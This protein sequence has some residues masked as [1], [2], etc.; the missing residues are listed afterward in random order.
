MPDEYYSGY[1]WY[2][3]SP[4]Q[5]PGI[6]R[7]ATVLTRVFEEMEREGYPANQA[8]LFGFSQGCLMTLEFGSR[9]SRA[10]A[11]YVGISG[12]CYD[13]EAILREMNPEVNNDNWL[14]THGTDDDLLPIVDTRNQIRRL[15]S[16]G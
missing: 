11:G 6:R 10:L 9:Y 5:F 7:S 12:Y 14:I 3:L 13:A 4:N 1:S 8:F 15:K 16:G 2:A